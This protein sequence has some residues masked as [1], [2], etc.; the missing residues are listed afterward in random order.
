MW[1]ALLGGCGGRRGLV[2]GGK[3]FTEQ[4]VLGE[5]LAQQIERR[6]G[7]P[8]TR[9]LNLGGTLLAHQAIVSG[10][11]DL[12]PEYTGTA[13]TAI[14]NLPPEYEA[15]RV[16]DRV[17]EEYR[18]RFNIEWLEP[19]G[20]NNSFVMVIRGE[21][22]RAG[23]LWTLSDAARRA[24][25]WVL[26]A[27]Y[28]FDRRPDG[29]RALQNTYDLRWQGPPT[30]MDLGLLYRALAQGQ[31]TMAAAN[32]TDGM[33]SKLDVRVLE[34]DKQAFPPYQ[35]AAL[36]RLEAFDKHPG[37]R[38][39]LE[40]LSG[41]ISTE[42]MQRLNYKVDGEHRPAREVAAEFLRALETGLVG[43]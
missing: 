1:A 38:G 22:A 34:D 37:L 7:V 20:F 5:I 17:R 42:T 23:G 39:A 2:V 24:E 43:N 11:I 13:L 29:L 4:L 32:G 28:E 15:E 18:R 26:G 35:A 40:E 6:L 19:F 31:V 16:F 36:V 14:L 30:T 10:G 33:L 3:N 21:D 8:V 12:Y 27:G 9:R 41:K 25:G